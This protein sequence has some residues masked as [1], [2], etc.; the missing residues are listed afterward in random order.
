MKSE[1]YIPLDQCQH[2]QLYRIA[3]RNLSVGVF[4]KETNGFVGIRHKFGEYFLDCEYHWDTGEPHGTACPKELLEPCPIQDLREY[5][6][7]ICD[8]CKR[9]VDYVEVG[10]WRHIDGS[11]KCQGK[12]AV[13]VNNDELFNWLW[14]KTHPGLPNPHKKV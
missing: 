11:L 10:G 2:G 5:L 6:G 3:S 9:P 1:P 7:S 12:W 14:E 8:G 13:A 4:D